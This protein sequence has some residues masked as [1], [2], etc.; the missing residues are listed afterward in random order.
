MTCGRI[1]YITNTFICHAHHHKD[2][3]TT[4][5]KIPNK[6]IKVNQEVKYDQV[7]KWKIR[8]KNVHHTYNT[9]YAAEKKHKKKIIVDFE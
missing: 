6:K 4:Y 5:K 9:C 8:G 2:I 7:K 1:L 3:Y